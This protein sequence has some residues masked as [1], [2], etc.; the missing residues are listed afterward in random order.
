RTEI[1]W[2]ARRSRGVRR[3]MLPS[4]Q[5]IRAALFAVILPASLAPGAAAAPAPDSLAGDPGLGPST[6]APWNPPSPVPGSEPWEAALRV[7]GK[8]VSLPFE[9]LGAATEATLEYVESS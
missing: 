1:D 8:I 7:P 3:S 9:A 6:A 2:P 4:R 5:P